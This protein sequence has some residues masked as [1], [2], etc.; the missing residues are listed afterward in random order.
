M[1]ENDLGVPSGRDAP[2][3]E[4]SIVA[5]L[6]DVLEEVCPFVFDDTLESVQSDDGPFLNRCDLGRMCRAA[7][8][9]A[10]AHLEATEGQV[11]SAEREVVIPISDR[12][13]VERLEDMEKAVRV[14][15]RAIERAHTKGETFSA[16]VSIA[17]AALLRV[18]TDIPPS[19]S[20]A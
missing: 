3:D 5:A 15:C 8:D 12:L 11:R 14:L 16:G 18:L 17:Y 4:K 1:R 20:L 2:S 7:I 6:L 9:K 19:R 10:K 13:R